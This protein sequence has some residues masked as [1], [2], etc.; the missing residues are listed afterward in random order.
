[1]QLKLTTILVFLLL[2]IYSNGQDR[3]FG[4]GVVLGE[5]TGISG[6]YW[7]GENNAFDGAMAWSLKGEAL[8]LHIDYLWHNFN[9]IQ[10]N[11]GKFPIYYGIGGFAVFSDDFRLGPQGNFGLAYMFDGAPLD[12]FAEIRPGLEILPEIDFGIGGGLGVRFYF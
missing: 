10:A 5:P 11:K 2:T 7:T 8:Y 1:M 4:L 3:K 6:K 9:L 12:I